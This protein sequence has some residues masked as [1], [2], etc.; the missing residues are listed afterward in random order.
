MAVFPLNVLQ[1]TNEVHLS[2]V[3]DGGEHKYCEDCFVRFKLDKV[4]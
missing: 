3:H 2:G 4:H 1:E